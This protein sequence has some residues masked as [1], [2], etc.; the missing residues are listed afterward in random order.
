LQQILIDKHAFKPSKIICVGRNYLEHI[1]ELNNEIPE[2]MVL[3][4]KPNS[5]ISQ[6]LQAEHCIKNEVEAIHYEAEICFVYQDHQFGAV[7][8]GL[9]LTKRVLQSKL[10]EKGLPWERAKAFDGAALFSDFVSID[11]ISE[12]LEL[13]L[14]IDGQLTQLAHISHMMY[15]PSLILQEVQQFVTLED[16]DIVMTGTP[17]GVGKVRRNSHYCCELKDGDQSLM[18][19]QWLAV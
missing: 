19:K 18:I 12:Q 16:G 11:K 15:S 4:F 2:N 6:E 17:A 8:I 14:H 10:K 1:N 3:F 9:D 13:T 7:G 5:A